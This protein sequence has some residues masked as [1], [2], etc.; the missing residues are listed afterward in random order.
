[1]QKATGRTPEN[2][3]KRND[4]SG[5]SDGES[6]DSRQRAEAFEAAERAN[7]S[8]SLVGEFAD[9]LRSNKKY[10]MIPLLVALLALGALLVLGGTA[11][12]PFIYALF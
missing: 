9:F 3:R 1:M 4:T 2:P 11:A 10:W 5:S 7:G 6:S 8:R 12:A